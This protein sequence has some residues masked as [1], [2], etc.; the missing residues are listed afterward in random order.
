MVKISLIDMGKKDKQMNTKTRLAR[1]CNPLCHDAPDD[2]SCNL[3]EHLLYGPN[4]MYQPQPP[5]T[6]EAT[7]NEESTDKDKRAGEIPT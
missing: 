1:T 7:T 3:T 2:S 6:R 5:V 4:A